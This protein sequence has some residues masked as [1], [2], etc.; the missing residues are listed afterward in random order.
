MQPSEELAAKIVG[1]RLHNGW[2]DF[3]LGPIDGQPAVMEVKL[4]DKQ[5]LRK[6]Q[7]DMRDVLV[8]HGFIYFLMRVYPDQTF[9][10]FQWNSVPKKSFDKADGS[11][12]KPVSFN[13]WA[14]PRFSMLDRHSPDFRGPVRCS[15]C[16]W[17]AG[18]NSPHSIKIAGG[19]ELKY[20]P[21][22]GEPIEGAKSEYVDGIG[23][24]GE[25]KSA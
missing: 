5:K 20:C 13:R 23:W 3:F 15:K 14:E 11:F 12:W 2:P 24:D 19:E 8:D 4:G 16:G 18:M 6:C 9:R 17:T 22:C 10:L 25:R 1:S 21:D 7:E